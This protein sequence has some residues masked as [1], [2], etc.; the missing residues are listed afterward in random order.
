MSNREGITRRTTLRGLGALSVASVSA[1]TLLS[2]LPKTAHA[3]QPVRLGYQF[4]L[5]GAPAVVAIRKGFFKDEGLT[6]DPRK[7]ASGKAAR[8]AMIAGSIDI[9]TVGITPFIVGATKGNMAAL[10]VVCYAGRTG[11]V[12]AKAGAGIKAVADLR[13]KKIASKVGSTL[14]N[15]FQRSRLGPG[16]GLGRRLSRTRRSPREA[17]GSG[18]RLLPAAG[19]SEKD[20]QIVNATFSDHVSALASGSV[21]AF[22]G[23]E[24][25]ASIA[26]EQKLAVP[27]T[28]YYKYD[29]IPNMLAVQQPFVKKYPE[30]CV[31]FLRAWLRSV[32]IFT[33]EPDTAADIMLDVYRERGYEINDNIIRSALKRLIVN[34]DFIPELP[35]YIR[36][37]AGALKAAG[38]LDRI[39]DP[40]GRFS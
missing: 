25:F 16:V 32:E 9:G 12:M 6:I 36:D 34:P 8:D 23:L 28:D 39:P 20:Y 22:L 27:V 17:R 11:V 40:D 38:R 18:H 3:L 15:V 37:Q 33:K 26:E 31:A 35:Q 1:G 13:G 14:D 21:D 4:H 7:F 5:W 2:V 29:L 10:A 24:P 30:T 19:L